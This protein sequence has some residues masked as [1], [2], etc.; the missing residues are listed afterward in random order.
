MRHPSTAIKGNV[1]MMMKLTSKAMYIAKSS[2]DKEE[3]TKMTR[4]R[5]TAAKGDL[6]ISPRVRHTQTVK[7]KPNWPDTEIFYN[8]I[9]QAY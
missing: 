7:I 1:Y 3:P 9:S 2:R 8:T 5:V 4:V 6:G